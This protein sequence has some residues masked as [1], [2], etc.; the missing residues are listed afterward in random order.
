MCYAYDIITLTGIYSVINVLRVFFEVEMSE[1][2][3]TPLPTIKILL[4]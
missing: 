2:Q 3:P 4:W 1:D